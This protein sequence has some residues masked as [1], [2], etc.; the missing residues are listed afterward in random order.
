MQEP[1]PPDRFAGAISGCSQVPPRVRAGKQR[2]ERIAYVVDGGRAALGHWLKFR[3]DD[4][5]PLLV[6][7][8]K[9]GIITL[10]RMSTQA[11]LLRLRRR[12]EQARVR[13][14]SP[15][16]LRRSLGILGV[17]LRSPIAP[18]TVEQWLGISLNEVERMSRSQDQWINFR[19]PLIDKHLTGRACRQ[20]F[21]ER[22]PGRPL[23][24]SAC[25]GCA[26]GEDWRVDPERYPDCYLRMEAGSI[27]R[28]VKSAAANPER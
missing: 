26:R 24:E 17:G 3:G 8:S 19:Y 14:C 15:H 6:P 10:R 5:G 7:V 22:Y 16:D 1:Y 21:Q 23:V 9:S 11:L 4:P 13:Q 27:S 20:W 28:F 18:G 2:R 12:C 25:V